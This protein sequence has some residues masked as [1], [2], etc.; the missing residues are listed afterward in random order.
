MN[1]K[2][3]FKQNWTQNSNKFGN[4][5]LTWLQTKSKRIIENKIQTILKINL[6]EI[7]NIIHQI[8]LKTNLN[9]IEN[10][11]KQNWT[12]NSIGIENKIQVKLETKFKCYY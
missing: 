7:E 3:N 2:I 5:I 12:Q 8:K 4:E 6:N 10:K 9:Q 11:F 1:L